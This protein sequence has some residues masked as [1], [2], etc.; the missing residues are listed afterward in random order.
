MACRLV[1]EQNTRSAVERASDEN[2]LLL[3]T[4]QNSTHIA[5]E[6]TVSHG[7]SDDIIVDRRE[8]STLL[9]SRRVWLPGEESYVVSDRPGEEMV[10]LHDHAKT[11]SIV[12]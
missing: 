4:R 6:G 10:I 3:A 7:H 1:Q 12:F 9:D 2:P 5:N 11:F 8:S